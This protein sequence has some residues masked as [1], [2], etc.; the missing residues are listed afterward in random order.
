MKCVDLN[1]GLLDLLVARDCISPEQKEFVENK[2]T[3]SERTRE[4]LE[5]ICR[6]SVAEY[7]TFLECLADNKQ[8]HIVQL[9]DD[10]AGSTLT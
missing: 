7:E 8:D 1:T 4:L 6:R 3:S 10:P 9:I 2:S 5:M